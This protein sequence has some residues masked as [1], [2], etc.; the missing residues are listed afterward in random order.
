M[1]FSL[2]K[3]F[4]L[5]CLSLALSCNFLTFA[6]LIDDVCSATKNPPFCSTSLRSDSRSGNADMKMLGE[7][8]IKLSKDTINQTQE[9]LLR[10]LRKSVA[11]NNKMLLEIFDTC[12]ENYGDGVDALNDSFSDLQKSDFEG[13][14]ISASAADSDVET[15][16]DNFSDADL[17]E[18]QKL[19]DASKIARDLISIVL[20][21]AARLRV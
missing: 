11:N 4:L 8:S 9:I 6:D 5:F 18:P 1:D 2:P 16:D 14:S 15:C 10:Q 19:V 12:L 13:M 20:S 17:S 21:I 7:I 3:T